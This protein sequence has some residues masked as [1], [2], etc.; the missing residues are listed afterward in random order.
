MKEKRKE[1]EFDQ[2]HIYKEN[3]LKT[4]NSRKS[5]KYTW[6]FEAIQKQ[7]WKNKKFP[8]IE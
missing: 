6:K 7:K 1:E 4:E 3:I 5:L 8:R 2:I